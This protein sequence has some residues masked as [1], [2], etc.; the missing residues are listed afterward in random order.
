MSRSLA[1]GLAVLGFVFALIAI[2]NI[3]FSNAQIVVGQVIIGLIGLGLA[4]FYAASSQENP[5]LQR[6]AIYS[7]TV[8]ALFMLLPVVWRAF[9]GLTLTA[10]QIITALVGAL[11]LFFNW[12]MLPR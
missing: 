9:T 5:N 6:I 12:R 1:G 10:V 7:L 2:Y 4:F 11:L 8:L 3:H